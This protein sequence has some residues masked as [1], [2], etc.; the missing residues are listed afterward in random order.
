MVSQLS[1][2]ARAHVSD[3]IR[4]CEAETG[5][6]IFCVIAEE[7]SDYR[8]TPLAWGAFTALVLPA[9]L[10][11]VDALS[12]TWRIGHGAGGGAGLSLAELATLQG[13]TFVLVVWLVSIQPIRRLLTPGGLKREQVRRRALEQFHAHGLHQTRARTGVLI[14][15]SRAERMAEFL[16]DAGIAARV[17]PAAWEKPMAALSEAMRRGEMAA[18]LLAAVRE[19]GAILAAHVPPEA[20]DANELPD[21]VVELPA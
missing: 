8:E 18:G 13:L 10:L 4:A 3:A 20:G 19:T 16:A 9:L 12:R 7:A 21:A 6:E 1:P 14:L 17:E 11:A 5:A 15:L 2:E